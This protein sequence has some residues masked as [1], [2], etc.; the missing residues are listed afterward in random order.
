MIFDTHLHFFPDALA[1]RAMK[2]LSDTTETIACTDGTLASTIERFD[3]WGVDG[4]IALHIATNPKQQE[5]VNNFAYESQGGR[6]L[7][8]GSVHPEAENAISELQ[9]IAGMG[10][11]GIKLHPDYQDF[12]VEEERIF[13]IY[14]ECE[15]LHLPIVFHAGWDPLSPDDIHCKPEKLRHVAESFPKL[16]IIA[17][18]MGAAYAPEEAKKYLSGLDNLWIDTA[19]MDK[20]LDSKSFEGM[21]KSFGADRILFATDCPWSK[22]DD[23]ISIIERANLSAKDKELIYYRNAFKL[24]GIK[25]ISD[26]GEIILD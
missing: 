24:F 17:A 16:R 6:F 19:V 14:A 12:Y 5:N 26:E 22:A 3:E 23:I 8:F 1:P 11:R 15:R 21:V 25:D 4:G 20:F 10:L 13:P 2:A 18:H 7:S 9:R